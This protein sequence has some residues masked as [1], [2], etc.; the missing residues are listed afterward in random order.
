MDTP[1]TGYLR[2]L[3]SLEREH[4][5]PVPLEVDGALPPE[6]RG[7]LYRVGPARWDIYGDRL[8]HWFDGDGMVHAIR[9][10]DGAASYRNRFVDTTAFHEENAARRRLYGS[11]GTAAPG[12]RLHRFQRRKNRRNPA[13]TN[14]IV[15]AGR[16]LALCEGGRPW[17]LDPRDLSTLGEEDLGGVLPSPLTTFSAHPRRDPDTGDLWNFGAEPG[18]VPQLHLY[19]WPAA[20]AAARVATI[21]LP[22]PALIHDF[23]ITPRSIVVVATPVVTPEVPLGLALGQV[24]YGESL[25]YRPERGVYVGLID[26]ATLQAH[27]YRGAPFFGLHLA[28]AFD[29]GDG[30]V[31][32]VATYDDGGFLSIAF[33]VMRGPIYTG[34]IG[35]LRRLRID[36]GGRPIAYETLVDRHFEFPRIHEGRTGRRHRMIYGL[37]WDRPTD[38]PRRPIALDLDRRAFTSAPEVAEQWCGECV[39]VAKAGATSEADTWLLTLVLDAAAERSE[40]QV[41]DGA[42]LP[43]GPVA[44]LPLPHVVPLGFHGNW[45]ADA[46][47]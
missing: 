30:V 26:R 23:A 45:A 31:V 27:W 28:N 29:D 43:A 39:P 2:G 12:S 47:P 17:R 46:A 20:G 15:H 14:V 13:N 5:D 34:T 22:M 36:R 37:T 10:G 9:L 6:L 41:F 8:H 1:S 40:L 21:A 18:R 19:R 32:D 42:D 44:R 16:L 25:R 38:M 3:R 24:S 33:E 7:T 11:F 35:K 4:I